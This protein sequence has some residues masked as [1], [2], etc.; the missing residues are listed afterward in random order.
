[1]MK[2]KFIAAVLGLAMLAASLTGCGGTGGE[3]DTDG[4]TNTQEPSGNEAEEGGETATEKVVM[5]FLAFAVPSDAAIGR[6]EAAMN[7][8]LAEEGVEIDLMI[9]D[10]ASFN[11]QLPLMLS[12]DEQ[13][14][15]Y[16]ALGTYSSMVNSGYTLDLEENDLIQTYGQ[17]ILETMGEYV[18][19]CRVNGILYGLPQNR[20]YASPNGYAI[21]NEY[22][23]AIGYEYSADEINHITMEELEDI[24]ARLH[25]A[26]P[27]KNVIKCQPVARTSVLCD[28]PGGDWYGVLMDPE[29][30]L[31]LTDLFSTPEYLEV[32][33]RYYRWNQMGYISADA[34]T[35]TNSTTDVSSGKAMAYACGLKAGIILQ[36]S[37]SNGRPTSMFQIED[38]YILPSASFADMPWCVNSNTE[39]PEAAM[40]LLN[41]LYTN[42]ELQTILNYGV[43]GADYVVNEEGFLTYPEDTTDI[44][45]PNVAA[46]MQNE[47]ITPVWE[48]NEATIWEDTKAMNDNAT[49][50]LAMGFS[51]DRTNV[52]AEYT[53]LNNV[54]EEYRYQIEY[55]FVEPEAGIAEMVEK[56]EAAGLEKYIAEKQ[57][58]LNKWAEENNILQ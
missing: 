40:K 24:F 32:C 5:A 11:Q 21:V 53:A 20:D 7:E 6:T 41:A 27:E 10:A 50:S 4:G 15:V 47:F 1:M 25:E 14:D 34:L 46:F 35:D 13:V 36:E 48:G 18:D 28:Y 33:Q 42:A 3:E 29:N 39:V 52:S 30:S 9:M 51:F 57:S 12:G 19:G 43:E 37:T 31:E 55:G 44:Y 56:M 45:H 8:I 2:K 38:E 58:Q 16:S 22:L 17:G 23:D 26:F 54:Y 49:R